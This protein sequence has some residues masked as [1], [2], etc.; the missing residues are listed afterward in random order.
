MTQTI[1]PAL[2]RRQLASLRA[3]VEQE[4]DAARTQVEELALELESMTTGI[5]AEV[6]FDDED[7][8][9]GTAAW[10][11]DRVA[12]LLKSARHHLADVEAA[13][14]RLDACTYGTCQTCGQ[15]IAPERLEA[16]PTALACVTCMSPSPLRRRT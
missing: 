9:G 5:E 6:T 10:D 2:S 3:V 7:G 12:A 11:R 8:E 16:R 14:G 13:L 1:S 4:L 15:P